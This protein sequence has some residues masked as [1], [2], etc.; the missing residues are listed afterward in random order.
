M[1]T[2]LRWPFLFNRYFEYLKE[3]K[4]ADRDFSERKPRRDGDRPYQKSRDDS[5]GSTRKARPA[6]VSGGRR[7]ENFVSGRGQRSVSERPSWQSRVARPENPDREKSPLIPE[8]ITEKD[9]EV[10][11]RVQLKT[12]TEENAEMVARHLAMVTLLINDDP[13]LAHKHA[14]A[15]ARRAGRIALV[16]ETVGITAYR[17]GDFALALR[18]LLTH[19]RISGS[20]DQIPLIVDCERGLGRP[21]KALEVGRSVD[22]TKLPPE[23][24]VNLAIA[25]SGARLDRGESDLAIA[26]LEIKELDLSKV[27]DYSPD[28]FRAYGECLS[29]TARQKEADRWFDLAHRAEV[30]LRKQA[31]FDED[32]LNIVEEIQIPTAADRPK[33]V[34]RDGERPRRDGDRPRRDGDRP[35]GDGDFARRDGDRPRRGPIKPTGKGPRRDY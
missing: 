27:F 14:L 11:A 1:A 28:L 24:R 35:R 32:I 4:M 19:R 30:A 12:L 17:V 6:G 29:G 8:E 18:E 9:L 16:R 7:D 13:E 34:D 15:A 25:M 3:T 23:V 5:S 33:R 31:G 22:R 2:F 26:E 20:N 21:D 10:G